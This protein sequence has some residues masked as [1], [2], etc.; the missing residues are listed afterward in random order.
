MESTIGGGQSE[1]LATSLK[2][3]TTIKASEAEYASE[4]VV[5][6]V[7]C[8][9][10]E[11]LGKLTSYSISTA[12]P[13]ARCQFDVIVDWSRTRVVCIAQP[14]IAI[15]IAPTNPRCFQSLHLHVE[16]SISN[17]I[18][19]SPWVIGLECTH[20]ACDVLPRFAVVARTHDLLKGDEEYT[21]TR[22]D[23]EARFCSILADTTESELHR[24][25]WNIEAD[26]IWAR[27]IGSARKFLF[28][29]GTGRPIVLD[30]ARKCY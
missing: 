6:I 4:F 15:I 27:D 12:R 2:C 1:N 22:R 10:I 20:W 5:T 26:S 11:C 17:R 16:Y 18:Y 30:T 19:P 28:L 7:H 29:L 14:S 23:T 9:L 13:R 3:S 8:R 25:H 24:N 21:A